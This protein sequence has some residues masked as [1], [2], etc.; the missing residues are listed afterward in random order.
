V[1]DAVDGVVRAWVVDEKQ[2]G[3]AQLDAALQALTQ[4]YR[5]WEGQGRPPG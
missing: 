5:L 1:L 2:T 4:R 3:D